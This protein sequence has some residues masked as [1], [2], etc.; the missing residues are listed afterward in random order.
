VL[1]QILFQKQC[2]LQ[3]GYPTN[4]GD[5]HVDNVKNYRSNS[6]NCLVTKLEQF[7]IQKQQGKQPKPKTQPLIAGM[8]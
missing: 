2:C 7:L 1:K 8:M 5:I 6:P 3:K 4:I